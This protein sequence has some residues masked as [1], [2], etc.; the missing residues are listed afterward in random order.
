MSD[1][2]VKKT[3]KYVNTLE[4]ALEVVKEILKIIISHKYNILWLV[5]QQVQ[6]SERLK[7]RW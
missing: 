5:Y 1:E 3:T 6:I 7:R 4:E 2:I